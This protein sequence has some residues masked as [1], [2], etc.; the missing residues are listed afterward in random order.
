MQDA[1][2]AV[3]C[4]TILAQLTGV[5]LLIQLWPVTL[6]TEPDGFGTFPV[7]GNENDVFAEDR[8][9]DRCAVGDFKGNRP[10]EFS[11]IGIEA[12]N[13]RGGP[14]DELLAAVVFND[15]RRRVTGPIGKGTPD[16]FS[17]LAIEGDDTGVRLTA[18]LDNHQVLEE[19]GRT[20]IA[21][22]FGHISCFEFSV[23]F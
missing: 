3:R 4:L 17:G 10:E 6:R 1:T 20:G 14:A 9:G 15:D 21:L 22:R 12:A 18:R 5:D 7:T 2:Q 11:V 16:L 8:R 13:V 19:H 23:E